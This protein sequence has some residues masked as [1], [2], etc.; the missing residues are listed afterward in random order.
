LLPGVPRAE[1]LVVLA[2]G[3][4][5]CCGRKAGCHKDGVIHPADAAENSGKRLCY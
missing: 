5:V 2:N 3:C 1:P 4:A